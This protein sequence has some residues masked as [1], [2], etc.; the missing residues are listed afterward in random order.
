MKTVLLAIAVM[1][2]VVSTNALA[3][4]CNPNDGG[5]EVV[6]MDFKVS[7]DLVCVAGGVCVFHVAGSDL[8]LTGTEVSA[9]EGTQYMGNLNGKITNEKT[10]GSCTG[11]SQAVVVSVEINGQKFS[12]NLSSYS[13]Y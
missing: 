7:G 13:G 10:W 1:F 4:G 2:S 8:K 11:H 3:S 12:G 5:Q 9:D 6:T